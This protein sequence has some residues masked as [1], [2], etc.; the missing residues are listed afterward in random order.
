[1][2]SVSDD[3]LIAFDLIV[4]ILIAVL[5][6]LAIEEIPHCFLVRVEFEGNLLNRLVTS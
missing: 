2:R 3:H 1:M 4:F 6:R 5:V